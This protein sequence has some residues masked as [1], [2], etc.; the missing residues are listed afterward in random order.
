MFLNKNVKLLQS[1]LNY[2]FQQKRMRVFDLKVGYSCNNNCIHCVIADHREMA[3]KKRGNQDRDT[4]EVLKEINDAK[5]R[6]CEIV[7]LTGGEP[8]IR[9]DIFEILEH[10][11]KIGLDVVIQTNGRKLSDISFVDRLATFDISGFCIALHSQKEKVHDEITQSNGSFAQTVEGIRNLRKYGKKIIGKVVLSK[12]NYPELKLLLE[13]FVELGVH[14]IN[15]A[16]PHA[17]GNAWKYFDDVVPKY[18]DIMPYVNDTIGFV[19]SNN[20]TRGK[21]R[22]INISFEAIPFCFLEGHIFYSSD[23]SYLSKNK[24]ESKQLSSDKILD[25]QECRISI[26]SKFPQCKICKYDE[27]CEGVWKE[28]PIKYGFMEFKAIK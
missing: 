4:E 2:K 13:F 8:L 24:T 14:D 9:K 15:V 5:D 16:F 7:T 23:L 6:G 28:Y 12:K 21:D 22:H 25:W 10:I 17:N 27:L 26:K 18:T 19:E 11:K 1:F 20:S 3:I